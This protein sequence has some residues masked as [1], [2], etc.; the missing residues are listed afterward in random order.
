MYYKLKDKLP[1]LRNPF[2]IQNIK[3]LPFI[4]SPYKI[5]AL[6]QKKN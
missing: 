3:I 4:S 2:L 6:Y 5:E 1:W